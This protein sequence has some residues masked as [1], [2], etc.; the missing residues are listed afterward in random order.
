MTEYTY[1]LDNI[2]LCIPEQ[3]PSGFN[4]SL[5]KLDEKYRRY[6]LC[7]AIERLWNDQ[8]PPKKPC[9]SGESKNQTMSTTQEVIGTKQDKYGCVILIQFDMTLH[10]GHEYIDSWTRY[11]AQKTFM[12]NDKI[13]E[14]Y[15]HISGSNDQNEV[16]SLA[17]KAY[18]YLKS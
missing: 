15:A 14:Y 3:L 2:I 11:Y 12:L 17:A 9:T 8:H 18:I 4:A 10:A 6:S 13:S 5:S 16:S 7:E 1:E